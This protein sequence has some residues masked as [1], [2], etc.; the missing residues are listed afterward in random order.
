[1]QNNPASCA[2]LTCHYY[3]LVWLREFIKICKFEASQDFLPLTG[4]YILMCFVF[5][6]CQD[7]LVCS[8][9]YLWL[10]I[11]KTHP[12]V[13]DIFLSSSLLDPLPCGEAI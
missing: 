1:M 2:S 3:N 6:V 7:W 12:F 5:D 4:V 13:L 11:C 8:V 9:A 10:A